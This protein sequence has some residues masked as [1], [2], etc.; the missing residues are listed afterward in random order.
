LKVRL[1]EGTGAALSLQSIRAALALHREMATF[2][3]AGVSGPAAA[4]T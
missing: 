4:G 3:Q 2:A 1:G